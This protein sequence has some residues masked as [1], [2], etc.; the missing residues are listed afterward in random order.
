MF[1]F[2]VFARLVVVIPLVLCGG[3]SISMVWYLLYSLFHQQV[4][5]LV[6]CYNFATVTQTSV[7]RQ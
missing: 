1:Q 6:P 5:L 3:R 4:P 7:G 2:A